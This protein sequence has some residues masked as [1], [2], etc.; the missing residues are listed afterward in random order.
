MASLS[1][2]RAIEDERDAP[3]AASTIERY[4]LPIEGAEVLCGY[5][6]TQ[7]VWSKTLFEWHVHKGIDLAAP[8]GE[9]VVAVADGVITKTA[10]DPLLG[11]LIEIAHA[12]GLITRYAS[13]MTSGIVKEGDHVLKGQAIGA[14]GSSAASESADAPH[15]HFEAYR[16]G[17]WAEIL[18]PMIVEKH[19]AGMI[20]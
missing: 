12:D 6:A 2:E 5:S 4:C 17:E 9:V 11:Y 16:D 10:K 8:A 7:P 19:E 13:L 14:A 20:E 18:E 3:V 1:P 15:V